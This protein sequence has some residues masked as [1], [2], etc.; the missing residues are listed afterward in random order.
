MLS[1]L[2][3]LF[4][5]SMMAATGGSIAGVVADGSGAVIPNVAVMAKN[6][7][8]GVQLRSLT[9]NAGFYAFPVLPSGTYELSVEQVGFKPYIQTGIEVRS[10]G[11]VKLDVALEI[12]ERSET[13]VVSEGLAQVETANTQLGDVI[14]GTKMTGI[15]VNGRSYTDLLALQPGV[16]P[17][18]A[19]QPNA[20]MM[21][22][23]ASAPPS[24][25]LNPGDMSVSG[26]RE[27]ANGFAVN[28]SSVQ[29]AFNMFAAVVPNLDSIEEFR[30][31]TG[32]FDAEYGNYSGGQVVVTTKSGT[33]GTHGSGFEF[34][35]DTSM[36][37]RN[38]F[39]PTRAKYDRHQF[40]G[41][42]GG[43]LR[44][45]KAFYFV[46][47]QGTRMTRG[48]DTGLISVPSL[49]NRDGD[50]SVNADRLTGTVNGQYWASRLSGKLGYTVTAGMPYY[51]AGCATTAQ[52]VFPGAKIPKSVWATPAKNL[53]SYIPLPN[54]GENIF[55]TADEDQ[56]LRDDKGAGRVDFNTRWGSLSAYYF[57]DDYRFDNPYPTGQG[58][59]NVPGFNALS[60]GRAQ[61]AA[62]GLTTMLSPSAVNELRL[63]YMRT[64][65]NI[66]QPVGGVGPTLASQGFVDDEGKPGIVALAPEIEGIENIAFNDF[67][68]GVNVTGVA[69]ANN[70]YQIS[71]NFSKV[72]GRHLLKFGGN[73][74]FDQI[75]IAP[76]ATYNGTFMFQGTETGSDFADYLLG[77][78]SVYAQGDSKHFYPR[79][80]YAGLYAQDRWQVRPSLTLNYGLRWDVLPPWS[81]KYNQLQT[82][83][84]GQQSVVY[85]G[86]PRGLV[87]P[88][89]PGV[90]STLAPTRYNNF[91]PRIG[92]AWAP[93]YD[94]G[95][96]GRL[97]G[98]G[99]KTSI[100]A[101]F[102]LYYTAIE[103][104]SAGIMSANP[105]YGMDFDSFGPPLMETPF[106]IAATGENVGQRFPS[107]IATPGASAGNPNNSVDWARY[108]PVAHMPGFS[109]QNVTP[110]TSSYMF[111][112]QREVAR[113]TTLSVSYVGSQAH[114]L[115]VLVAAN[116]GNAGLCLSL[117]RPE[118]VMPGT[119][120]CGPFGENNTYY[121]K[122]GRVIQGTRGPFSSDFAGFTYQKT[123]GNSNFNALEAS[124][125]HSST[126]GELL[127]GYTYGKSLDQSS[128][129]S[130]AINPID[131]GLSKGL[132]AF[133][134][135]HNLVASYNLVLPLQRLASSRS[136]WLDGWSLSGVTRLSS[137]LPVTLFNNN[138]TSLLGSIPNGINSD[139]LDTPNVR[140]GDLA[141]NTNPRNGQAAFD[142]S[143]F[144]LPE[145]GTMG[146]AARRFFYGPGLLNFDAALLK[147]VRFS[148]TKA[149]D[150]RLEAFNVFN[151]AQ[152]F[153]A[154]AVNGNISSPSFGQIVSAT[155]PRVIQLGAKFR[156]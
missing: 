100:R 37:A 105:P 131:G 15:P 38:Y 8:T 56:T 155:T 83:V 147:T 46:D 110:Y 75:N 13:M 41:T 129:L 67:T 141:V 74:H 14:R 2:A 132:S 82:A 26:Q 94:S 133:D 77:I 55:S 127:V 101:G 68:I 135:R 128:S 47:Y 106:V 151:H 43:A 57:A 85:P 150:V 61:M 24:G 145:M 114:H 139:G 40:G 103:G 93:S 1:L 104:L 3:V 9:N 146:T 111:S 124:L 121:A 116:P 10:D 115:L 102:G 136:A 153:G 122:D 29:E 28:G 95:L 156:F 12:G 21:S 118:D 22:G 20:V 78:A 18:S 32:N 64:A 53:L 66:G 6:V 51:T 49:K 137:G 42:I 58:G 81:E 91:A 123:I 19:K 54:K 120:T 50:F 70:T 31:L 4:M 152:F 39:A 119:A 11:A 25:D 84:L 48:V 86:A 52:C 27:T 98:S 63:S 143:L 92:L 134:L 140:N 154:A 76:N 108:L 79:N 65:N 148:D 117:S 69:Q 45:D 60:L 44:K 73:V 36:A 96:L 71:D 99:Q 125:R 130:E 5:R 126:R 107:S 23:C 17:V 59:A 80:R 34:A 138:D 112:I 90:P 97:F 149:L 62:V 88:G 72:V 35:R 33:N 109:N 144:S 30:V 89:D 16:T 113:N 142:T 87:F 7:A